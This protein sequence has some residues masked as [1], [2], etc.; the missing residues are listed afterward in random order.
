MLF[1]GIPVLGMLK[2]RMAWQQE[3][4]TVLA[5][6]I[7]NANTPGYQARDLK[8]LKFGVD[9]RVATG[10]PVV[11]LAATDPAHFHLDGSPPEAESHRAKTFETTPRGNS[12]V[13]EDEVMR[14]SQ[15]VMDYQMVSELYSRGIGMIKTALGR[16]A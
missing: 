7:A 1:G 3:R 6:N 14:I 2:Q 12:V 15:N 13:L 8:D 10:E 9:G 16:S 5:Q 4:Q 11:Q